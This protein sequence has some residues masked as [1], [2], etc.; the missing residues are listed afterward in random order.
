MAGSIAQQV[1]KRLEKNPQMTSL[2]LYA[3]FPDIRPNTIRHYKSGFL[4]LGSQKK[5]KNRVA[6]SDASPQKSRIRHSSI[7]EKI[8]SRAHQAAEKFQRPDLEQ[9]LLGFI[10]DKRTRIKSD[11]T[12]LDGLQQNMT[13]KISQFLST[14]KNKG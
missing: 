13:H 6:V 14:L 5:E 2:E 7:R 4:R 11:I 9:R 10:S 8:T 12:S 1:R 3:R